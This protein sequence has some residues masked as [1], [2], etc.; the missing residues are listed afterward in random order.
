[1]WNDLMVILHPLRLYS[2][3]TSRESTGSVEADLCTLYMF[4]DSKLLV[5]YGLCILLIQ[6]FMVIDV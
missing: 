1:M 2:L 4:L 6:T 3:H 5:V